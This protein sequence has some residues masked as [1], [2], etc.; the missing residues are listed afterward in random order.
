MAYLLSLRTRDFD[1]ETFIIED[2][3]KDTLLGKFRGVHLWANVTYLGLLTLAP[4]LQS[5][6]SV[7]SHEVKHDMSYDGTEC[8]D[9]L[10]IIFEVSAIGSA[11]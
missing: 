9:Y 10:R 5:F 4:G 7:K 11:R 8:E 1:G 6:E 3:D 2:A